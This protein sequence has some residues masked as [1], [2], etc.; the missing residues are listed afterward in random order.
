NTRM[1]PVGSVYAVFRPTRGRWMALGLALCSMALFGLL[2][3][4]VPLA[5]ARSWGLVDSLLLAGFGGLVAAAML[6]FAG[7]QA[8]PDA[9][10]LRVKNLLISP[11][12]AWSDIDRVRF[13]ASDPWVVLELN[14]GT[15]CPVMGIQRADGAGAQAAAARLQALVLA[16]KDIRP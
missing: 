4:I 9:S 15:H 1:P 6:R 8:R 14:D 3:I 10:G 16:A 5:G 2:A 12:I 7:V 13:G 11:T